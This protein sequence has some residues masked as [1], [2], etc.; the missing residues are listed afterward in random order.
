MPDASA[1]V[2]IPNRLGL[3]ARPATA[4][5]QRAAGFESR[6]T[7]EGPDGS[8]VDGKSVM[9]VLMLGA[10]QGARVRITAEGPDA[11]RAV[12]ALARLIEGGFG[13]E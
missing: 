3:H 11:D 5:A 1:E 2:E 10:V 4:L 9:E 12:K 6:I 7:I 13:E 8:R